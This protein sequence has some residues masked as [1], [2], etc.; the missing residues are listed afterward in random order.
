MNSGAYFQ[1]LLNC[2]SGDFLR[3]IHDLGG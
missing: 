1:A 2:A 3:A